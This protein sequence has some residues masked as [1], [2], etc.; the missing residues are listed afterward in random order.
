MKKYSTEI[1][2]GVIFAISSLVW[3]YFEKAMGWHDELIAQQVIYTNLFALVAIVIF[4]L[5]LKEKR[6]KDLGGKMSWKQGFISGII[7]SIVVAILTPLIQ[8]IGNTWIA[9]NYFPNIINYMVETGKMTEEGAKN[10]FNL[11]SYMVQGT[12]GALTMGVVTSAVV[13]LFLKKQ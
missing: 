2:W 10:Y 7:I 12:F 3:L 5:A 4:V 11:K 6:K 1:K 9:P 13:A 8:Y